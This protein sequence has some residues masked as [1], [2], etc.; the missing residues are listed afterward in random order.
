MTPRR[1][2]ILLLADLQNRS[3]A[4]QS[5]LMRLANGDTLNNL[6]VEERAA[7]TAV[8]DQVRFSINLARSLCNPEE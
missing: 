3:P 4:E 8:L 2:C 5:A 7:V 1:I 6:T